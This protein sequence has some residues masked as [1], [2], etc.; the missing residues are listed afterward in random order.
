MAAAGRLYTVHRLWWVR[1]KGRRE[2][3]RRGG[4]RAVGLFVLPSAS[5]WNG[6]E[7]RSRVFLHSNGEGGGGGT[8]LALYDNQQSA[9]KSH[10]QAVGGWAGAAKREGLCQLS[11]DVMIYFEEVMSGLCSEAWGVYSS[12]VAGWSWYSPLS[13]WYWM[14]FIY[15]LLHFVFS[16]LIQ[17]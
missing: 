5:T 13:H 16:C 1:R 11:D 17:T 14:L 8:S 2:R 4:G 10:D 9:L 12:S 6:R 7:K 15:A 3:W